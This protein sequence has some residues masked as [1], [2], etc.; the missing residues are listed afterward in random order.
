[1][2]IDR[3]LFIASLGGAAAVKAMSHEARSEALEAYM[4]QQLNPAASQAAPRKFPTVAEV[5]AQIE[6]RFYRRGVGNLFLTTQADTKVKKLAPMP[7]KPTLVDFFKLRFT[8]TSNHCF[9]SANRAMKNKMTEEVILACLLHDT[10]Q[11]IM[12]SDH[13]YWGAQMYELYVPR[14]PVSLSGTIRRYGST[15]TRSTAM[16][17]PIFTGTFSVRTTCPCLICRPTTRCSG[18]TSGTWNRGWLR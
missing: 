6:T 14:R 7:A 15:K 1:M 9:Q 16:S 4:I 13:G 11:E 8:A 12:K 18:I 2:Q 17:I 5:E 3:R 10:I